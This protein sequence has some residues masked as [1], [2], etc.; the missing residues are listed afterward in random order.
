MV[1]GTES[2]SF[3]DLLQIKKLRDLSARR[4]RPAVIRESLAAMQRQVAGMENPLLEAGMVAVGRRVAFRHK[5]KSVEPVGGQF[6]MDF[7]PQQQLVL[8]SK[9]KPIAA[10]ETAAEWFA[11]GVS[12]EDDPAS[13]REAIA[14]YSKVLEL[15][16][17]HAAAHINL[18][19][20]F[21]NRQD[22]QRA[23]QHYRRA[24]EVDARYALAY[25]DLGNVL[26]ETG[27]L[28]EAVRMYRSAIALAPTYA[29]AHYNLA[30]A[31]EKMKEPRKALAHWRAYLRMDA[32]GPWAV[33]ARNQV[34]RIL[35]TEKLCV[36]Y[37]GKKP[38]EQ[39]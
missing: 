30:L 15:Q 27:R 14:A 38:Q 24:I 19:T 25:F 28:P 2:Y 1:A 37:R 33:H 3:F 7:D 6:L 32:A 9:I 11:K 31:Y 26:D 5:G 34:R 29:D 4:V 22:F 18:G 17:E 36:V 21:Y 20:L 8:S 23:E 16:P 12:L 13:Y 10:T 39:R 35:E